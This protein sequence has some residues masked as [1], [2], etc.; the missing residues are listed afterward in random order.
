MLR[1]FELKIIKLKILILEF[2]F[3]IPAKF[4]LKTIGLPG[5]QKANKRLAMEFIFGNAIMP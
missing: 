3:Q 4:I 1:I 2:I 5:R